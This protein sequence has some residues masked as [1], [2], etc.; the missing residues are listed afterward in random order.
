MR[1]AEAVEASAGCVLA[2]ALLRLHGV[3][4]PR[5]L[6]AVAGSRASIAA[7]AC[8]HVTCCRRC[9][10]RGCRSVPSS[11]PLTGARADARC[12]PELLC[13]C[14]L[15][16]LGC[17]LALASALRWEALYIH[18]WEAWYPPLGSMISTAG[19]LDIHR[20]VALSPS[21][22]SVVSAAGSVASVPAY[23]R[24]CRSLLM[25]SHES[26]PACGI[27]YALLAKHTHVGLLR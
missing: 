24:A 12:V 1:R 22:G 11:P 10:S 20:V 5:L 3:C 21:L 19:K 15:K 8:V 16:L 7:L 23:G 4:S 14:V 25:G 26:P 18:R 9:F 27:A 17:C 13:S 6:P 2:C